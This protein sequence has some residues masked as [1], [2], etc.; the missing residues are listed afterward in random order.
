MASPLSSVLLL[1]GLLLG[2]PPAGP[3]LELVEPVRKIWDKGPHNAFTDLLRHDGLWYCVFREGAGHA[4]GAGAIRV[5][6]SA[7]GAAWESAALIEQEGVDLRDPHLTAMPDGS[8]L[9]NGAAAVPPARNPLKDHYSFVTT[10]KDGKTWTRPEKVLESWHWLWRVTW[11]E[12]KAFGVAY[13]FGPDR[14][15]KYDASLYAGNDAQKLQQVTRFEVPNATEATLRFDG[16]ALLCLQR[17]DGKPNSAML[18]RS[19]KPYAAWQWQDTGAYFG[20]PNFIK[21]PGG[22]WLAAGRMIA[23]G[24]PRTV[25]CRL[26]VKAGK[27]QPLLTLPSGGDNSYPGL[28]WHDDQLWISYYSSHEGKSSIYLAR[29]RWAGK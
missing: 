4:A 15:R 16:D 7:D 26:D 9:I 29:A 24:K 25:V 3:K 13:E 18:G 12:G 28:A 1:G 2:Q 19:E 21:T 8:L 11:H 23:A 5:L 14:P 20:G 27:L 22:D 17:R 6:T 10:S